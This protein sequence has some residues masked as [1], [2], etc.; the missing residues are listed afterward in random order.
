[1][2]NK[3]KLQIIGKGEMKMLKST[4]IIR[5]VDELGRVVIPVEIREEQKIVEGTK[6]E[7]FVDANKIVFQK[8][9]ISCLFCGKTKDI[10]IFRNNLVCK[11]CIDEM[12]NC[13][14]NH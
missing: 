3:N 4:G 13:P 11:K 8:Y 1:M 5:K 12:K 9:Q 2:K 14:D 6:M 10:I 7:V